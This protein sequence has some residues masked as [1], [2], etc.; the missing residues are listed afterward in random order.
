MSAGAA[1]RR[2]DAEVPRVLVV[3]D[4]PMFGRMMEVLG[5]RYGVP[6]TVCRGAEDLANLPMWDFDVCIVDY[7]LGRYGAANG[8]ELATYLESRI[9]GLA[10]V[11]VSQTSTISQRQ[12]PQSIRRFVPK[13]L[14]AYAILNAGLSEYDENYVVAQKA[15][16]GGLLWNRISGGL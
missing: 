15:V 10:V 2:V 11:L 6:M 5:Q 14:G 7:D 3:D 12:W 1:K 8:I 4:D 9:S 16:W 13:S